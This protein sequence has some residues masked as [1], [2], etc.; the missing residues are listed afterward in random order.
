M[1]QKDYLIAIS[2]ITAAV[3]LD[4]PGATT[5]EQRLGIMNAV[6]AGWKACET[7]HREELEEAEEIGFNRGFTAAQ[8]TEA[9]FP[10]I[11]VPTILPR[12]A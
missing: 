3:W 12:R 1:N 6:K 4:F 2:R 9:V 8:I 5:P 10:E 7:H 11:L